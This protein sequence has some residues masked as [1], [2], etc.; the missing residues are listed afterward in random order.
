MASNTV[1]VVDGYVRL[2]ERWETGRSTDPRLLSV[3]DVAHMLAVML[4]FA[5]EELPERCL[6]ALAGGRQPRTAVEVHLTGARVDPTG[7]S[8]PKTL[9]ET[10]DL[11]PLG[12]TIRSDPNEWSYAARGDLPLEGDHDPGDLAVR[13][14]R[15]MASDWGYDDPDPGLPTFGSVLG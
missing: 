6:S 12:P 14:L 13:A 4:R 1:V 5:A 3:A 9:A 11:A 8:Q 7:Q 2:P 10:I 15:K